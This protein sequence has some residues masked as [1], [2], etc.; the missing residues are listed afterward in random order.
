V[1]RRTRI[2]GGARFVKRVASSFVQ[3]GDVG[4]AVRALPWF[5]KSW[6]HYRSRSTEA[7]P[8]LELF[9]VLTERCSMA[10]RAV[11]HYFYQDIWAARKVFSAGVDE[12]VDVGSRVDGFVA[13]CASFTNVV[14]VDIRGLETTVPTIKARRGTV[15][16]LPFADRSIRSLS[17]L[18][19][20]EHVGLGRYGDDLDPLGSIKA[21]RELQRVLAVGGNLY[22]G[23]PIGRE[24]VCFNAHRVL[25]PDTV[26]QTF[27][28]LAL[29]SFSAV[30]DH[31]DL[32][33]DC[34]PARFA[35]AEYSCGLF[36]FTRAV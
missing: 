17:C 30:D 14:Y 23:V 21:M 15:L 4:A 20:V 34:H 33:E 36:H 8:L 24:R 13:H 2:Y 5:A 19:V 9:P 12:H 3:F 7:L 1:L 25:S 32:T 6:I 31:G 10:G 16:G 29:V 22:F 26:L 28:E 35:N 27:H 18:H 11:G